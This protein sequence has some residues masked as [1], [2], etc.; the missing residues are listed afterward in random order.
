MSEQVYI[1][2]NTYTLG[3]TVGPIAGTGGSTNYFFSFQNLTNGST[4]NFIVVSYNF[5]GFSGYAGPVSVYTPAEQRTPIYALSFYSPYEW[6]SSGGVFVQ[7]HGSKNILAFSNNLSVQTV[8][9]TTDVLNTGNAKA[10][11]RRYIASVETGFNDPIGGT[12]ASKI[13]L[14]NTPGE[15]SRFF[16]IQEVKP[17]S[18]YTYSFW[19]N[20]SLTNSGFNYA[21]Y[22]TTIN[23]NLGYVLIDSDNL[24]VTPNNGWVK[25]TKSF[26]TGMTQYGVAIYTLNADNSNGSVAYLWGL[27]LEEGL[28][29]T[30]FEIT[31][32]HKEFT[33]GM[34]SGN[35][36]RTYIPDINLWLNYASSIGATYISPMSRPPFGVNSSRNLT[37]FMDG[38]TLSYILKRSAQELSLLPEG[39]KVIA[40]NNF[41]YGQMLEHTDD[42]ITVSGINGIT[43]VDDDLSYETKP[44]SYY[45]SWN[46]AGISL[47]K[48]YWS[49]MLDAIYD[50]G[51]SVD[52]I[53]QDNE[54]NY[55][56]MWGFNG[57]GDREDIRDAYVNDNRYKNSWRGITSWESTMATYG[58]TAG[59]IF[60]Y[61]DI[62]FT[63]YTIWN[64]MAGKITGKVFDEIFYQ[65]TKLKNPNVLVSN[66]NF[67]QTDAVTV[68]NKI[69]D[70]PPDAAGHPNFANNIVGN[71]SAP[72]LYGELSPGLGGTWG[73]WW[74]RPSDPTRLDRFF[75]Q[76]GIVPE[77]VNPSRWTRLISTLQ[78]IRSIKRANPQNI[79]TPWISSVNYFQGYVQDVQSAQPENLQDKTD[80]YYEAIRHMGVSGV[81]HF[82]WWNGETVKWTKESGQTIVQSH[83]NDLSD[84]LGEINTRIGGSTPIAMVTERISWLCEYIISGAP[85]ESGGYWWRVTP[86]PGKTITVNGTTTIDSSSEVGAWIYTETSDIPSVTVLAPG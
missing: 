11:E 48:K 26:T 4:Y 76:D 85:A 8:N 46:D 49:D 19:V 10:W 21:I 45:G 27:Q 75:P 33:E 67:F 63:S 38:W 56:S 73:V 54:Y 36:T 50:Y 20:T 84:V 23:P 7:S 52:Q 79:I 6:M 15:Y 3:A 30:S 9:F 12:S 86:K 57:R 29:A 37:T 32:G 47:Y 51:G 5:S 77:T 24:Y 43:F 25:R 69:T 68:T 40:S 61:G 39:L 60:D 58:A 2:G 74:I 62:G 78:T 66:Y 34:Y 70:A 83:Y 81:K 18:P 13:T 41:D 65:T 16:Q 82:L 42:K 80:I 22:N 72:Y 28:T 59:Y 55:P 71:I 14:T 53:H 1:D 17:N 35:G 44:N 64:Y 31:T